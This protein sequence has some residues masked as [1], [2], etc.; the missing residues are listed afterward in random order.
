MRVT[1]G[2]SFWYSSGRMMGALTAER[3]SSPERMDTTCSQTSMETFSWA[4]LVEAP[5]W[6]VATTLGCA[7]RR[8]AEESAS[9]GSEVNT[10]MPAP[11]MVPASKAST[12]ASSSIMPPLATFKMRAVGFIVASSAREI[13][14]LVEAIRGVWSVRKSA[15][16]RRS[17]RLG[18]RV[19][20]AAAARFSFAY[21]S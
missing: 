3:G 16:L 4:S 13:M 14:P 17:A 1:K 12:R 11:A 20:D 8:L 21:G 5:R 10:S 18:S 7:I 9:G 15:C 19:T 2:W 6:G